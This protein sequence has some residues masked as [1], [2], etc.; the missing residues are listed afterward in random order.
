MNVKWKKERTK[1]KNKLRYE[2]KKR[3]DVNKRDENE[4]N[5]GW[6]VVKGR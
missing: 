4:R 1:K 2:Q 5:K 3:I 6:T